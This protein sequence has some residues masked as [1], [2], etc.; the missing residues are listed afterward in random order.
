MQRDRIVSINVS[1]W[2]LTSSSSEPA[3]GSSSVL[4]EGVGRLHLETVGLADDAD[5]ASAC[6]GSTQAER[7]FEIADLFDDD[8]PRFGFRLD[9]V[10]VG[11]GQDRRSR[12]ADD[13]RGELHGEFGGG[14]RANEQVSVAEAS[15]DVCA[16]QVIKRDRRSEG[17]G[18]GGSDVAR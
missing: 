9:D 5:L 16:A 8:T 17:H 15:A 11:V 10:N 3:G 2:A 14:L 1:G 6:G 12:H 4:E 13:Q 7:T 18:N